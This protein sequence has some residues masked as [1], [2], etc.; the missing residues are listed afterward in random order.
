ME[1]K[2]KV[3][4]KMLQPF[5]EKIL[6]LAASLRK[7][8]ENMPKCGKKESLLITLSALDKKLTMAQKEVSEDA[9]MS[10][11]NKHPEV[12]QKLA[13]FAA[14]DKGAVEVA[15]EVVTEEEKKEEISTQT[16]RKKKRH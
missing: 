15:S 8:V 13:K 9:V 2:S 4:A 16:E 7:E 3:S 12:L 10:Y 6:P 11:V 5:M 1:I 14:S